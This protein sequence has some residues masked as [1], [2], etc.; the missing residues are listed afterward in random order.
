MRHREANPTQRQTYRRFPPTLDHRRRY[1][2]APQDLS[3]TD[4]RDEKKKA[5]TGL[6]KGFK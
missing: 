2:H 4:V 6:E 5:T 1:I 3:S